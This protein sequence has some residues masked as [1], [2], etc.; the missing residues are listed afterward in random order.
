M[1][2]PSYTLHCIKSKYLNFKNSRWQTVAILKTVKS[3]YLRNCLTDFGESWFGIGLFGHL[4]PIDRQNFEFLKIQD[5][6]GRH[7]ENHR[8][9]YITAMVWPVFSKFV[10]LMQ[11]GYLNRTDG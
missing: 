8:N 7:P 1:C 10:N 11:N 2:K 9:R 5:G 3:P 4:Q 6:S